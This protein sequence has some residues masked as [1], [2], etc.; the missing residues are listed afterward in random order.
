MGRLK[1]LDTGKV[2]RILENYGFKK[3][4]SRKHTTFKKTLSSGEVL[5]TWVPHGN[6]VTV[7]VLKY[8]MKQTRIPKEEFY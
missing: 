3:V 8:I 7:F 2:I 4:R 6:T 5:T 1:P